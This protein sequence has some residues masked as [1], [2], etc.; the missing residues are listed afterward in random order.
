[1]AFSANNPGA[2]LYAHPT[3]EGVEELLQ[4]LPAEE[5]HYY[6]G[7]LFRITKHNI[8][9]IASPALIPSKVQADGTIFHEN[10]ANFL[11]KFEKAGGIQKNLEYVQKSYSKRLFVALSRAKGP[12]SRQKVFQKAYLDESSLTELFFRLSLAVK[13]IL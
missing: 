1:M 6:F 3:P 9:Q 12:A 10:E 7:G 13:K 4:T 2:F 5:L 8:F 11:R